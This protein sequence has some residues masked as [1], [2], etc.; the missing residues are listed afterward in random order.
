MLDQAVD[1]DDNRV[2]HLVGSNDADL[3]RT[4]TALAR[5]R[6]RGVPGLR[7]NVRRNFVRERLA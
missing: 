6:A 5:F 2:R 1:A 7:V 3:L 4:T